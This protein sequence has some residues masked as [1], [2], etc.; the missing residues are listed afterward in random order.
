MIKVANTD[1][2]GF[3]HAP[4]DVIVNVDD[5]FMAEHSFIKGTCNLI[6]REKEGELQKLLQGRCVIEPGGACANTLSGISLLGGKCIFNSRFAGNPDGVFFC[7]TLKE[8]GVTA[9]GFTDQGAL[10]D[11]VY[12]LVTPDQERTF[13]TFHDVSH[14]MSVADINHEA[15][16]GS[17]I[18]YLEGFML[19]VET[20]FEIL[21]SAARVAR[22]NSRIT[23]FCPN[24]IRVIHDN[25]GEVASLAA[26]S[27]ILLMNEAEAKLVTGADNAYEACRKFSAHSYC[28]AVS[29]GA[30]EAVFYKENEI[31]T[32][33][34]PALRGPMVNT[35]GAGDQFAAGFLFGLT[36][37]YSLE[38]C[39]RLALE[40]GTYVLTHHSGRPQK[41]FYNLL[42]KVA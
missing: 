6:G 21:E 23:V 22:E 17:K 37:D 4:V 3:G 1:V 25:P 33:A 26:S 40:C 28:G 34:P 20:G 13:G 42:K 29:C 41:D 7:E 39:A 24:D 35:N 12:I 5:A 38:K 10:S 27:D 19:S 9:A 14:G 11:K 15:V 18:F 32:M 31:I 16:A 36:H 2:A 8:F 30:G